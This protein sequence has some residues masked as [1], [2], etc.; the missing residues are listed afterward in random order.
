MH[1]EH[2]LKARRQ[3]GSRDPLTRAVGLHR[4][5]QAEHLVDC[6]IGR[7]TADPDLAE[8]AGNA[9]EA[10]GVGQGVTGSTR[11]IKLH[12]RSL[13]PKLGCNPLEHC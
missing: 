10:I 11:C 7:G 8:A 2:P 5:R 1:D 3:Q 12:I 13:H 6:C 4:A 9:D